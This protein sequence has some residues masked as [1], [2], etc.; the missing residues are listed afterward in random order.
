MS[1]EQKAFL[2]DYDEFDGELREILEESLATGKISLLVGFVEANLAQLKDPHEG[3]MLDS[4]WQREVE[5]L[6]GLPQ[7]KSRLSISI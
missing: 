7:P 6:G 2:F 5:A 4:D 3:E 1:I